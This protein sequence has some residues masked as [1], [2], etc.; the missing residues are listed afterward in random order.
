[1]AHDMAIRLVAISLRS[2]ATS[3]LEHQATEVDCF[4]AVRGL[5]IR[6]R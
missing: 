5:K 6:W 2:I 1:M 3:E 4:F